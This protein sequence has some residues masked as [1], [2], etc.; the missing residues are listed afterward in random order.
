MMDPLSLVFLSSLLLPFQGGKEG[1]PP[2]DTI[3]ASRPKAP[4]LRS[5]GKG[6][7][8]LKPK[9]VLDL[10]LG[11]G[12]L[13]GK[14]RWDLS[15]LLKSYA[16]FGTDGLV[17]EIADT[18]S[19]WAQLP[20]LLERLDR[21]DRIQAKA[22]I[23][24]RPPSLGA[25]SEPFLGNF[26]RWAEEIAK[27]AARHPSLVALYIP[28]IFQGKNLFILHPGRLER[29][30]AALRPQGVNLVGQFY[31]LIPENLGDYG[32][33]LD[34]IVIQYTNTQSALNLDSFLFMA[35]KVAPNHW[36]VLGGYSLGLSRNNKTTPPPWL[37]SYFL[38]HAMLR[39]D[40]FLLDGLQ[41]GPGGEL[42]I[43]N[44]KLSDREQR[45]YVGALLESVRK[46]RKLRP[47]P[48]KK[49]SK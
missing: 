24:I 45:Q 38:R 17:I 48:Q 14:G 13:P 9:R 16:S 30:R 20:N 32:P 15:A 1:V 27:L 3:P 8:H 22:W 47:L 23:A 42:Q 7:C 31:D 44:P 49:N 36:K 25:N 11:R 26:I 40:G 21:L 33:L 5:L 6:I 43:T 4:P 18:K 2:K 10:R 28:Q 37:V 19:D 29:M 41:G 34:G 12:G 46:Y 35:K 39:C